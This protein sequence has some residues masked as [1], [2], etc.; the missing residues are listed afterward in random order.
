MF[1]PDCSPLR[2]T[3]PLTPDPALAE[4]DDVAPPQ[5]WSG[6][7]VTTLAFCTIQAPDDNP[8]L[9]VLAVGDSHNTALW[10]AYEVVAARNRWE[11]DVLGH[12]GCYWTAAEQTYGPGHAADDAACNRW[13]ANLVDHLAGA[14]PYDAIITT[15][16][17][18]RS[19]VVARPGETEEETAIVGNVE[20]WAP[21]LARGTTVIALLDSPV[22]IGEV[23]TCVD[24][25]RDRPNK[26]C[27]NER[28]IALG[29]F[30]AFPEAVR[31]SSGALL[32]DLTDAI[33]DE[34][35]CYPVIGNVMAYRDSDHVSATFAQTMGALLAERLL[36]AVLRAP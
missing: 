6:L 18:L 31:R 13:S 16:S 34:Q 30:S 22:M 17:V 5:C 29:R 1:D 2:V 9:R 33:C 23:V 21:E 3:R 4:V 11:I 10:P 36:A 8:R 24:Q 14:E 7:G 15:Y 25:H 35:R 26:V 32:V 19:I 12:N 28:E 27:A 20:V